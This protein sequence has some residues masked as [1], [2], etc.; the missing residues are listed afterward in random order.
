MNKNILIIAIPL[1]L[2]LKSFCQITTKPNLGN[3]LDSIENKIKLILG[4][5][6]DPFNA[7]SISGEYFS[8]NKLKGKITLINFWFAS[9]APCIAE[10]PEINLLFDKFKKNKKFQML[11]VTF[12]TLEAAKEIKKKYQLTYPILLTSYDKCSDL[13]FKLGYPVTILTDLTGKIIYISVGGRTNQKEIKEKF[14][15]EIIPKI[16]EALL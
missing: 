14:E 11:G 6:F 9:C 4:K 5:H 7:K 3:V 12:E 16:T 15:S 13:S 10:F 2:S 8:E 1:V